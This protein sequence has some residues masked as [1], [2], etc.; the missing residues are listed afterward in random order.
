MCTVDGGAGIP[1]CPGG[2]N[3][4]VS[5]TFLHLAAGAAL[6][7]GLLGAAAVSKR[8][9]AAGEPEPA[10]KPRFAIHLIEEPE[11]LDDPLKVPIDELRLSAEPLITEDDLLTYVKE[12]DEFVLRREAS[13]KLMLPKADGLPFVV[14]LDGKRWIVGTFWN[15]LVA[16][17][18]PGAFRIDGMPQSAQLRT[19]LMELGKYT[20]LF[21]KEQD[22]VFAIYLV[23]NPED[24]RDALKAPLGELKLADEPVLTVA[25][26]ACYDW[27]THR[28]TLRQGVEL[29]SRL[30]KRVVH[31]LFVVVAMGERCYTGVFFS[32]ITSSILPNIPAS[33]NVDARDKGEME[34]HGDPKRPD[35]PRADARIR[36]GL[37]LL[38][39]EGE[40]E[41]GPAGK[42]DRPE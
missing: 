3:R 15:A 9:K 14:V 1:A 26:V 5:A 39:R 38:V 23:R 30:P 33:C 25:D 41:K 27:E 40:E 36:R 42:N 20:V 13:E 31:E 12:P 10:K 4:N 35:D 19:V 29:R 7:I 16:S 8:A 34:I 24:A 6:V 18:L 22:Q 11:K 2:A 37:G 17:A 21:P 32:H 28:L